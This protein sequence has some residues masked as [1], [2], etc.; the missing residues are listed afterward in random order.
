MATM[1][2][3][4]NSELVTVYLNFLYKNFSLTVGLFYSFIENETDGLPSP[5][6]TVAMNDHITV[7]FTIFPN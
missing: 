1:I 3:T 4:N 5:F 2:S 7:L 6:E